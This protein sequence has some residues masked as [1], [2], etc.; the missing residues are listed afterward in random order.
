MRLLP[1][2]SWLERALP[3]V[4]CVLVPPRVKKSPPDHRK[5]V[6]VRVVL[7]PVRSRT[8]EEIQRRC[9]ELLPRERH[10]AKIGGVEP[11]EHRVDRL[12]ERADDDLSP[13]YNNRALHARRD[14]KITALNPALSIDQTAALGLR[15]RIAELLRPVQPETNSF[16]CAGES[17]LLAGAVG[18][19]T[20]EL[21]GPPPR[22][23]RPLRSNK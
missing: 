20:G 13:A 9:L 4:L 3:D 21:G 12:S 17:R 1:L 22:K 5:V 16:L 11:V 19:A 10:L 6:E 18:G 15:N 2:Q 8:V 23:F 14:T 7:A